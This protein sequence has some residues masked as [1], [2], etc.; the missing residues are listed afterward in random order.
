MDFICS[1]I[2][3]ICFPI[4]FSGFPMD[5]IGLPWISL[6]FLATPRQAAFLKGG[7]GGGTYTLTIS[8]AFLLWGRQGWATDPPSKKQGVAGAGLPMGFVFQWIALDFH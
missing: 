5:I 6:A 4:D 7:S 2:A 1:P 8:N 3:F